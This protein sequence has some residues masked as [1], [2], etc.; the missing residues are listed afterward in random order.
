MVV[1]YN[2]TLYC[3]KTQV[4]RVTSYMQAICLLPDEMPPKRGCHHTRTPSTGWFK[5]PPAVPLSPA[6]PFR[7]RVSAWMN[8]SESRFVREYC[9]NLKYRVV[10]PWR[11]I[12]CNAPRGL[13]EQPCVPRCARP[14]AWRRTEG[15]GILLARITVRTLESNLGYIFR[16]IY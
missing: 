6:M 15:R 12:S 9:S 8:P 10:D 3:I 13:G 16:Q 4:N 2:T 1:E 14:A 5:V 7:T 11:E